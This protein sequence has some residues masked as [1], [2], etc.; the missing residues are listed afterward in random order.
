MN[1]EAGLQIDLVGALRRQAALVG[2][3]AG[4][5]FIVSFWIAMLLPNAYESRVT[6]LVEPPSVNESLVEAGV[7]DSDLN[8]RLNLM[9]AQI[10][11]RP[12]LSRIIDEFD[13]YPDLS[14]E[15]TR[16]EVVEKMRSQ[17]SIVPVEGALVP[18]AGVRS[19]QAAV[20][21][22]QIFFTYGDAKTPPQVVQR[23][24]N[25]FIDKQLNERIE[26][27]QKSF[28]FIRAEEARLQESIRSVQDRIRE[29]KMENPG[30]LPEN[31][32]DN[33]RQLMMT[34]MGLREAER[35]LVE[36]T[37]DEKFWA[38]KGLTSRFDADG[39]AGSPSSRLKVLELSISEFRAGGFTDKHPDIVKAKQEIA[40]IQATIERDRANSEAGNE[41]PS[42]ERLGVLAERERAAQRVLAI[43]GEIARLKA[44]EQEVQSRTDRIPGVA[45]ALDDLD[46]QWMQLS[47]NLGDFE[48]RR[49]EAAVQA[50]LERRQLGEQFRILEPASPPPGPSAPNRPL[51]L[52]LGLLFGVVL[53]VAAGV[54]REALGG[55]LY[56]V[57]E[58]QSALSIP[59]LA[60]IPAISFAADIERKRRRKIWIAALAC[61]FAFV[62]FGAGI[63]GYFY[64]NGMPGWL[65][66]KVVEEVLEVPEPA[67]VPEEP[68]QQQED[69]ASL[70]Y[71]APQGQVWRS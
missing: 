45:A 57:S 23:L 54:V 17:I 32:Q 26:I 36:A 7:A 59:V 39:G 34:L 25:D 29:I 65:K 71:R 27:T 61:G 35:N 51:I 19:K 50:N 55:S 46:R 13:L 20:N 52:V 31:L 68:E 22:F 53:G 66:P 18:T 9:V 3:V 5:V 2:L 64:V 44:E 24:A 58:V 15:M 47:K 41:L 49:L 43:R 33:Q 14:G 21:T 70:W 38:Q 11:A 67:D 30:T 28:E 16:N 62:N 12:R 48:N 6:M 1:L 63:G 60:A 8:T 56:G 37:G 42:P 40:S 10:L 69:T 4:M